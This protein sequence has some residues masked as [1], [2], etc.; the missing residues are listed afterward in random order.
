[1]LAVL[2]VLDLS[3]VCYQRWLKIMLPVRPC[4]I[5]SWMTV[6]KCFIEVFKTEKVQHFEWLFYLFLETGSFWSKPGGL[7]EATRTLRR[8]H[9]ELTATPVEYVICAV[10]DNWIFHGRTSG[11]LTN[12]F[13]D[14]R[15]FKM[16]LFSLE[17]HHLLWGCH[18]SQGRRLPLWVS[19]CGI[20][21]TS[22]LVK[23][24]WHRVCHWS[25]TGCQVPTFKSVLKNWPMNIFLSANVCTNHRSSR[26]WR[27]RTWGGRID[28]ATPTDNGRKAMLQRC[29][30]NL[31]MIGSPRTIFQLPLCCNNVLGQINWL[32]KACEK[33]IPQDSFWR[34]TM[35]L[36]FLHQRCSF[37]MNTSSW[38]QHHTTNHLH[39][40]LTCRSTMHWLKFFG[41]WKNLQKQKAYDFASIRWFGRCKSV[42]T[43]LVGLR[44]QVGSVLLNRSFSELCSVPYKQ[45]TNIGAIVGTSG[46]A[47]ESAKIYKSWGLLCAGVVR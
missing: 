34:R 36:R 22:G 31:W 4:S 26:S 17:I 18:I 14:R 8:D 43:T 28:P 21:T 11:S 42:K 6:W 12:P 33:C 44:E 25:L 40:L 16:I 37:W 32:G 20:V 41:T 5:L 24:S 35:Q 13:G 47:L 38:L 3:P 2:T 15:S 9:G 30:V 1:M 45:H 29:W 39:Y 10:G 27:R 23:H 7:H 46:R 19:T